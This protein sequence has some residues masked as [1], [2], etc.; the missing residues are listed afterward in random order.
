MWNFVVIYTMGVFGI[1]IC[2]TLKLYRHADW[3]FSLV[4]ILMWNLLH[5]TFS[6]KNK[7]KIWSKTS[8]V[9]VFVSRLNFLC[10]KLYNLESLI[11]LS[12]E[13]I[14]MF[15][16]AVIFI[17]NYIFPPSINVGQLLCWFTANVTAAATSEIM[18]P[19]RNDTIYDQRVKC[20]AVLSM[21]HKVLFLSD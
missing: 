3:R 2:A 7:Q 20:H 17:S 6:K 4:E 16:A 1:A 15:K 8:I 19:R 10:W 9:I 21:R 14:S 18:S 11:V 5:L 12:G 13:H